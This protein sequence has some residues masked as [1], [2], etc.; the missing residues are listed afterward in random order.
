MEP[1]AETNSEQL[2][3]TNANLRSTKLDISHNRKAKCI[4]DYRYIL[5]ACLDMVP[6]TTTYTI[7]GF[8]EKCYRTVTEQLRTYPSNSY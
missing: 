6:R 1:E 7:R 4:E 2:R 5:Q 3:P 8:W